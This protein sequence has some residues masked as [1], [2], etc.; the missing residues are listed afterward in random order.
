MRF[1]ARETKAS[2]RK[3]RSID[4]RRTKSLRRL[5]LLATQPGR[6]GQVLAYATPNIPYSKMRSMLFGS[7]WNRPKLRRL[8]ITSQSQASWAWQPPAR[9]RDENPDRNLACG[10]PLSETESINKFKCLQAAPCYHPRK[11]PTWILP[12]L[13]FQILTGATSLSEHCRQHYPNLNS[14]SWSSN[15]CP[16]M[17]QKRERL[18]LICFDK[19][20]KLKHCQV[21][22]A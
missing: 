6:P 8:F 16:N 4:V 19:P 21:C 3:L 2:K 14:A 7:F 13:G 9:A 5:P 11:P 20:K 12:C 22:K 17:E 15:C 18:M 1:W 10:K